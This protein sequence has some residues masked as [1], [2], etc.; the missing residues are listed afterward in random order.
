MTIINNELVADEN[1]LRINSPI[2]YIP[3]PDK[4][5]ALGLASMY[6]GEPGK[7]PTLPENQKRVYALQED[8][9]AVGI[10]QPVSTTAGGVPE[11][12]GS[13]V[14]LAVNGSYSL[15][16]RDSQNQQKYYFPI[17]EGQTG[18]VAGLGIKEEI[19]S[20]LENQLTV[21]FDDIDLP[22]AALDISSTDLVDPSQVDSRNLFRDVDYVITDGGAGV[23]TLINSF[24]EGT[25]IRARQNVNTSQSDILPDVNRVFTVDSVDS[26]ISIDFSVGDFVICQGSN[27]SLDN[28][29]VS[30]QV[31]GQ[32]TGIVDGLNYINLDNN[33]QL[34]LSST[35]NKFR[36]YCETKETSFPT[37]NV[38]NIDL[39]SGTIHEVTLN[40][41]VGNI[42]IGSNNEQGISSFMLILKQDSVGG[43]NVDFTGFYSSGSIAPTVTQG[44]NAVDVFVFTSRT[45]STW[46]VFPAGEDFGEIV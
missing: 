22:E 2:T 40:S 31:V 16:I 5:G 6:F 42:N 25:L 9:S 28:L 41:N 43:R 26:A 4:S 10:N 38:I 7:D 21:T 46:Y 34:K 30:Y 32:A 13:T 17:V 11:Y 39:N 24:E 37:S 35:N 14:S 1:K 44:P 20:L 33:L 19:Q 29:S 18:L 8:G 45:S 15:A 12:N 23:I 3:D 27:N 36:N